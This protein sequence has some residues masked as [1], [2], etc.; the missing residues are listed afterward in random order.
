M[1][2]NGPLAPRVGLLV[3]EVVPGALGMYAFVARRGEVTCAFATVADNT[4]S[5]ACGPRT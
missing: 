3:Q 2:P 1:P 4:W 5:Q